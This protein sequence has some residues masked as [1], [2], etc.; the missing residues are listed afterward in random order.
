MTEIL[1]AADGW[2]IYR[3]SQVTITDSTINNDDDC[4]CAFRLS[5]I[6]LRAH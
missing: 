5:P 3:S 6:A 4:V 1:S 2:D